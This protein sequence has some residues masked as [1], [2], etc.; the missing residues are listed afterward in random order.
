MSRACCFSV[1]PADAIS[2][3]TK[4]PEGDD[5]MS[6][7]KKGNHGDVVAVLEQVVGEYGSA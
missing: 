7:A 2:S 3:I 6:M 1:S 5:A 4:I